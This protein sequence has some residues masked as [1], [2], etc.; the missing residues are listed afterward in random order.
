MLFFFRFE[1]M[2]QCWAADLARRPLFPEISIRLQAM[3]AEMGPLAQQRRGTLA[4][5][6]VR[7][8]AFLD[9]AHDD[10]AVLADSD[11]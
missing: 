6:V 3:Q 5:H 11:T 1:L 4:A 10:S 7:N 9:F 2:L 8:P